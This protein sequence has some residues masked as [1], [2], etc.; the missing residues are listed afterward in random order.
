MNLPGAEAEVADAYLRAF[1]AGLPRG[2]WPQ[3][4]D[5]LDRAGRRAQ[6]DRLR[7]MLRGS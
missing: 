6:A 2:E 1:G 7:A 3:V 4:I 5:A